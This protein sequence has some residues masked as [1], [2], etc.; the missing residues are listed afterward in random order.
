MYKLRAELRAHEADVRGV[1]ISQDG[2]FIATANRDKPIAILRL[3]T[4]DTE[5]IL[6]GH[7]HF[8]NDVTFIDATTLVSASNDKTIRVIHPQPFRQF[9]VH[10]SGFHRL[11]PNKCTAERLREVRNRQ[12]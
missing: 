8:V 5:R 2:I 3:G 12:I 10:F 11:L 7:T 4:P 6:R 9:Y 1:A